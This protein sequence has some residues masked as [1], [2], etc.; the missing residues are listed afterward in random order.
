MADIVK[1]V[2]FSNT[3]SKLAVVFPTIPGDTSFALVVEMEALPPKYADAFADLVM[4]EAQSSA[5]TLDK[6]LS[7]RRFPGSTYDSMLGELHNM[8][9]LQKVPVANVTMMVTRSQSM[10]L[11]EIVAAMAGEIEEVPE[12]VPQTTEVDGLSDAE[13]A[14]NLLMQSQLLAKDADDLQ[15]QA[16]TLDPTLKPKKRGRKPAA[17]K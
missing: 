4:I 17:K 1:H 16:Y 10:P 3:G 7:R 14:K 5:D 2:G 9:H 11:A 8:G 12:V 13:Q 15:E 6:L